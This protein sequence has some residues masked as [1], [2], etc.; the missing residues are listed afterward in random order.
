MIASVL[1]YLLHGAAAAVSVDL[2]N[3]HTQE[4]IAIGQARANADLWSMAGRAR[5]EW[6]VER[7]RREQPRPERARLLRMGGRG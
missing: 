2:D 7:K 6:G 5:R 4:K 3:P 1:D